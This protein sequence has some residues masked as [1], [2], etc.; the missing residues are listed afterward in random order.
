MENTNNSSHIPNVI[1]APQRPQRIKHLYEIP[2]TTIH[3]IKKRSYIFSLWYNLETNAD[4]GKTHY[5]CGKY[6]KEKDGNPIFSY[7]IDTET[8]KHF[9]ETKIENFVLLKPQIIDWWKGVARGKV[10]KEEAELKA[11]H[12]KEREELAELRRQGR[13]MNFTVQDINTPDAAH[14]C[15]A[16]WK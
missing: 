16:S 11:K 1:I 2:P 4:D 12:D 8:L 3:L 13:V 6:L 5:Y 7:L 9:G 10:L 14:Y 15:L